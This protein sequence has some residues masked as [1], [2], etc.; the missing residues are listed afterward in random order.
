MRPSSFCASVSLRKSLSVIPAECAPSDSTMPGLIA[1][2]RIFRGPS[3][4]ASDFVIAFTAAFLRHRRNRWQEPGW[5]PRQLTRISRISTS[6]S[7]TSTPPLRGVRPPD[8]RMLPLRSCCSRTESGNRTALPRLGLGSGVTGERH[9]RLEGFKCR[10]T[11]V[12]GRLSPDSTRSEYSNRIYW[13]SKTSWKL[14]GG[15]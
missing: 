7:R 1:F 12:Y 4:L 3:S 14:G 2:T 13:P 10:L 9:R 8:R 6:R 11:I 5:L 15:L